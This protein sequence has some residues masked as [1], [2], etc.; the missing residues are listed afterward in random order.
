MCWWECTID[1]ISQV[2]FHCEQRIRKKK[3]H[4]Y[5]IKFAALKKLIFQNRKKVS[6]QVYTT[7]EDSF[8]ILEKIPCKTKNIFF[9]LSFFS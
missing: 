2:R 1:E 4:A 9:Q 3:N 8:G 7:S 5:I 6:R